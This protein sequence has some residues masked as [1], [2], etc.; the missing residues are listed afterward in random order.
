MIIVTS[1]FFRKSFFL[2][3]FFPKILLND[4][5]LVFLDL[6]LFTRYKE[7]VCVLT[8]STFPLFTQNESFLFLTVVSQSLYVITFSTFCTWTIS[9][10]QTPKW[11]FYIIHLPCQ[12]SWWSLNFLKIRL[13][14]AEIRMSK[15]SKV[16]YQSKQPLLWRFT[17]D[18]FVF[19]RLTNKNVLEWFL[20]MI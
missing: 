10:K 5:E 15:L 2:N 18:K 9:W 11:T 13:I 14:S 1:S 4:L 8:L 12:F 19:C 17:L 20:L 7:Q 16:W 6:N 3:I